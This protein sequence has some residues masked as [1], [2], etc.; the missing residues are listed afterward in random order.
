MREHD[1]RAGL[2]EADMLRVFVFG[3]IAVIGLAGAAAAQTASPTTSYEYDALGRLVSSSR[4]GEVYNTYEFDAVGNRTQVTSTDNQAPVINDATYF[5][6]AIEVYPGVW[7]Y[8]NGVELDISD[9]ENDSYGA[10]GDDVV[11]SSAW[12]GSC[13]CWIIGYGDSSTQ[14]GLPS[15]PANW[16]SDV[17]VADEHGATA[18]FTIVATATNTFEVQ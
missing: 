4:T 2:W 12:G 1:R 5:W 14:G 10:S 7:V 13:N 9:P 11:H 6:T 18:D 15:I 17:T 8:I 16:S 3:L